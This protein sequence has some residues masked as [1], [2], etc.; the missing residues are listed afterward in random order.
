M[1]RKIAIITVS[2]L[3]A[4]LAEYAMG[5]RIWG[6]GGTPGVWSGDIWSSHNSQF[7]LDPYTF[8]HI[9]HGILFYGILALA[10]RTL[11]VSTRLALAVALECGWEVLENTNMVIER[12]RAETISLNYYSDS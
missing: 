7:L 9:S 5:R 4:A 6:V 2:V 3:L 10:F 11:P 1:K 12:Y 8:T